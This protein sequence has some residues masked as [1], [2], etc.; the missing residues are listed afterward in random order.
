M[1]RSFES[2]IGESSEMKHPDGFNS[3]ARSVGV[4]PRSNDDRGGM[5]VVADVFAQL[6]LPQMGT[7]ALPSA[8][9]GP[10]QLRSGEKSAMSLINEIFEIRCAS[11]AS[12]YQVHAAW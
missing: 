10:L 11:A 12:D 1:P 6:W 2:K 8:V 7:S 5:R 4:L 9:F 3:A